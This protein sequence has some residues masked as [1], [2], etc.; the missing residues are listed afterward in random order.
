MVEEHSL[1]VPSLQS[2]R[3]TEETIMMNANAQG[4]G[5]SFDHLANAAEAASEKDTVEQLLGRLAT[6]LGHVPVAERRYALMKAHLGLQAL[7]G[8]AFAALKAA[9]ATKEGAEKASASA[10]EMSAFARMAKAALIGHDRA[11]G[12]GAWYQSATAA[13]AASIR[14]LE[15]RGLLDYQASA[16]DRAVAT[17]IVAA[18]DRLAAA[19]DAAAAASAAAA[20][21]AEVRAAAA[22]VAAATALAEVRAAAAKAEAEAKAKAEAKAEAEAAAKA[23]AKAA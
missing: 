8:S 18:V 12:C 14:V 22:E 16:L 10:K 3:G 7:A 6:A 23:E 1:A 11:A 17:P 21:A 2:T 4:F 20:S 13:R 5:F 15:R 9:K 19:V